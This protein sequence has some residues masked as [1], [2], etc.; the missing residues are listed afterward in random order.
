VTEVARRG[1]SA[2]RAWLFQPRLNEVA[3]RAGFIAERELLKLER[4]LTGGFLRNRRDARLPQGMRLA[5]FVTGRDE[6]A[7]LEVN[8]AAFADHPE[9]GRWTTEILEN[10][11]KQ[12]W[13]RSEELLMAW[14]GSALAG[15]CWCKRVGGEGEI[16]VLAVAPDV[17]GSGLGRA[18]VLQG[19]ALMEE[20]GDRMAF[21]YVD[22]DNHRAL[23]LYR[24]LGFYTDHVDRSFVRMLK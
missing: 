7:W 21:L 18:L 23:G 6:S 11:M 16:Y 10:R 2:L 13:F 24:S 5:P 4:Q 12:I 3:L 15:F 17:Q 14:D 8:N 9:N 20:K 19:L 1:G 22:A